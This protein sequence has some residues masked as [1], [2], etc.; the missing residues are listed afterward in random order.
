MNRQNSGTA[1]PTGQAIRLSYPVP[2]RC[3]MTTSP[4]ST[5]AEESARTHSPHAVD[6]CGQAV[7]PRLRFVRDEIQ[8]DRE[9]EHH[10]LDVPAASQSLGGVGCFGA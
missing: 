7:G 4:A 3:S 2:A 1:S 6:F 8:L 9:S 10:I 5:P